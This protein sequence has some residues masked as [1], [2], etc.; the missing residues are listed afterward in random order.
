MKREAALT[1]AVVLCLSGPA[2][3]GPNVNGT[4]VVHDA[5]LTY[6]DGSGSYPSIPPT[7]D[8]PTVDNQLPVGIPSD[9]DG[10]IWKVYAAFPADASPRLKGLVMGEQ[11]T[12]DVVVLRGELPSSDEL[13]IPQNGWPITTGGGVGIVFGTVQT[14]LM[15]EC[16]WFGGYG[17]QG[18]IWATAPHPT[19]QMLFVDD[20][21]PPQT[22]PIAGLSSIGFG[23]DGH[24]E[25][26][27]P[28]PPTGACCHEDGS[29]TVVPQAQ[30]S[31]PWTMLGACIP[32]PCPQPPSGA[33]CHPDGTCEY[34]YQIHCGTGDWRIGV[35]CD[36][37]PCPPPPSGACCHPDG[38]CEYLTQVYCGTDDWRINVPCDPNPC[39]VLPLGACCMG[40]TCS[41]TTQTACGGV[42]HADWTCTPNNCPQ[43]PPVV[44]D[45]CAGAIQ[46][47][48]GAFLITGTTAGAVNDYSPTNGCTGHSETGPD[49]VYYVDLTA[50]DMFNVTMSTGGLWDDGIYLLTD[51][52][53]MNSCVAGSDSDPDMST[54]TYVATTTRRY[55]LIVD[56]HGGAGGDFAIYGAN[57]CVVPVPVEKT[58]WGSIKASFR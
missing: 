57:Y 41:I 7:S 39:P 29:C 49:I 36:P 50:G 42:W 46:I 37:N 4:L 38:T 58:S 22:D 20:A 54:F 2:W 14:S 26:P 45:T 10:W 8:P 16:Y 11:F 48:C 3:A 40:Q 51:C 33:C 34:L 12:P 1:L 32:N 47:P 53:N 5:G 31:G 15:V 28:P 17:S 6:T 52:A 13:E 43:L 21:F 56:G 35:P 27:V 9:G 44:N 55:Y 23:V 24:T 19:Q 25:Y 30:C 18:G